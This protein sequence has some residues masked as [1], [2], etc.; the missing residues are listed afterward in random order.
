VQVVA[1]S[2]RFVDALDQLF[3]YTTW[4]DTKLALVMFVGA[5][6]LTGIITKAGTALEGYDQFLGW[7]EGGDE[8]ELRARMSFLA[9]MSATPP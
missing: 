8:T 9:M 3:G 1:R 7:E 2:I 4:R 5:K 6:S